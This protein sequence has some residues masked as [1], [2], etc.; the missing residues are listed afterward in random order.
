MYNQIKKV[1]MEAALKAG[2]YQ[3]KR[4]GHIKEITYKG[5]INIVTDVDKSCEKMIIKHILTNFNDHGILAEESDP[6]AEN[7]EYK[8]IIDPIDGTTNYAQGLP[9]Y[10]VSIGVEYKSEMIV[11]VV[12]APDLGEMFYAVK[13]KGAFLN[14]K[15]IFVSK[16]AELDNSFLVTGFA[17]DVR[18]A[19]LDNIDNFEILIKRTLAVR[20]LGSAAID[21]SYVACG[22]FDGFWEKGLQPWDAAAGM[23]IV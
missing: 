11:G 3:Q 1:A 21:M 2:A 12:Y 20:R 13:G 16:K 19:K 23:L 6:R 7:A 22:R 4:R 18:S 5:A 15:R 9:I 14:K 8:W 10:C 17:Y